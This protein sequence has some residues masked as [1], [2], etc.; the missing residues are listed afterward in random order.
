MYRFHK[1]IKEGKLPNII[2]LRNTI[3]GFNVLSLK[4]CKET[5]TFYICMN[6]HKIYPCPELN[7]FRHRDELR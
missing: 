4:L 5:I 3:P 6:S 2:L 7:H 1:Y